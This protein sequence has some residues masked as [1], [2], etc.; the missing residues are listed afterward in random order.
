[1]EYHQFLSI[2]VFSNRKF[3]KLFVNLI[4]I[5][6]LIKKEIYALK[7]QIAIKSQ[8]I[9]VTNSGQDSPTQTQQN[10]S[11]II[12]SQ[13]KSYHNIKL[14]YDEYPPI[15]EIMNLKEKLKLIDQVHFSLKRKMC[16]ILEIL[17]KITQGITKMN[18]YGSISW[19]R[20]LNQQD[21]TTRY[22]FLGELAEEAFPFLSRSYDLKIQTFQNYLNGA[23]FTGLIDDKGQKSGIRKYIWKVGSTYILVNSLVVVLMDLAK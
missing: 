9:L 10:E 11:L 12:K 6:N 16:N 7:T 20:C 17:I 18:F 2:Q 8:S 4:K 19:L 23:T 13:D 21:C 14:I 3:R 5:K 15:T 22:I 1:M